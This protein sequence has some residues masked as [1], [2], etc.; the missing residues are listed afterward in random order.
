MFTTTASTSTSATRSPSGAVRDGR[1]S[2]QAAKATAAI[3][4]ATPARCTSAMATFPPP[5]TPA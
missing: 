4:S 1:T 3:T 2:C 5:V